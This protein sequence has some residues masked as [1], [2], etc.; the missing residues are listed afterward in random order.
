MRFLPIRPRLNSA[1]HSNLKERLIHP[2]EKGGGEGR[3]LT[4]SGG[5]LLLRFFHSFFIVVPDSLQFFRGPADLLCLDGL[6][7][8]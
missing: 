3:R 7:I 1:K 6:Q 8:L 5:R 2:F 4:K